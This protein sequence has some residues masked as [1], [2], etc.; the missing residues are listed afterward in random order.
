MEQQAFPR[1]TPGAEGVSAAGITAFL[2]AV[3]AADLRL[4]SLMIVRHGAVVA[5][6]WWRP[7]G[8]DVA[9]A[10]YSLSKSFTATAIGLAVAEGRLTLGDPVVSFF[11]DEVPAAPA[12]LLAAMRVRDLLTMTSGHDRDTTAR[13]REAGPEWVRAF[14]ALPVEHR[15]GTRFVYNSGA[16][17]MLSAIIQRLTGQTLQDYLAPRL[18]TP[19]GIIGATWERSPEGI[20]AGGWGLSLRT[21]D[22]AR[23][24]LLYLQ[25]G[26]WGD[27]QVVPEAWVAEATAKQVSNGEGGASDWAQGYGYQFWRSRHGAYRGDGAHGQFCVVLPAEETVVAMT[28]GTN[29][30]QAL[31]DQVWIHLLPALHAGPRGDDAAL[32]ARLAGLSLAPLTRSAVPPA[33]LEAGRMYRLER[34]A[35]GLESIRL[36]W[37]ADTCVA[38]LVE[39][40]GPLK[41]LA[42]FD[43]W[44]C[45]DPHGCAACAC[46]RSDGTLRLDWAYLERPLGG[47]LM[48]RPVSGGVDVTYRTNLGDPP[49]PIVARGTPQ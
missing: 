44:L 38:T 31:L 42:A 48:V 37:T 19:L 26:R 47:T 18:L 3:A 39:R 22:I 49:G 1:S 43:R 25:R 34:N 5:E 16:S 30:M 21:E 2:D 7:Y 33:G 10:L 8:P 14:L 32:R 40:G 9:Q 4:H 23:F 36:E 27:R 45:E 20:N 28:A 29:R 6:G 13:M 24:G 12:P 17:Y 11:P 15:P 46:W 35:M 41:I